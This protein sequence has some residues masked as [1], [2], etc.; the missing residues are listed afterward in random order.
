M[1]FDVVILRGA[2]DLLVRQTNDL[3]ILRRLRLLRM[4]A[5]G[6]FFNNLLKGN[7]DSQEGGRAWVAAEAAPMARRSCTNFCRSSGRFARPPARNAASDTP[8][9]RVSQRRSSK[10]V[11]RRQST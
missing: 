10:S 3:Q 4:T 1:F 7:N 11:Q 6:R 8:F 9:A 5:L 2:K